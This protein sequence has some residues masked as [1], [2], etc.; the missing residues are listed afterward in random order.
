MNNTTALTKIEDARKKGALVFV[1][2]EW[3][4]E[5]TPLFKPEVSEIKLDK[6]NDCF[7]ISGKLMPKREVVDRI[8]EASGIDFIFG[9]VRNVTVEDDACGKR[10]VFT[11]VAQGRKMMSDGSY[12]TSSKCDYEFDPVLRAM[13]D[14][15]VT[16]LNAETKQRRR[17]SAKGEYYGS[18]LARYILELQKVGAQRANTGARLRVIRELVGMPVA[19]NPKDIEQPLVFGRMVQN[20]DYI[21]KTPE[22]RTMAT[23][24]ALGMDIST[25]FGK[26][27]LPPA[28]VQ[29]AE[30]TVTGNGENEPEPEQKTEDGVN[31][32]AELANEAASDEDVDFPADESDAQKAEKAKFDELTLNLEQYMLTYK[33]VLN[34]TVKSGVNPYVLAQNEMNDK[35]A[36]SESRSKMIERVR[37]FLISKHVK[38][39]A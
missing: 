2:K 7:S 21:L 20:T 24:K 29:D 22:G 16:E 10:T 33:E 14:Y 38:G 25:L 5:K 6:E 27:T 39:V 11:A 3:V 12:R 8:G 17:K 1:D 30:Y 4:A 32:A 13:L 31:T 37:T 26:Q 28:P 34:T 15:D 19:F 9:E 23:A 35:N 36:T 18:T